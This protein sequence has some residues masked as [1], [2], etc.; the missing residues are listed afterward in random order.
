MLARSRSCDVSGIAGA[1][2]L[3]ARVSVKARA[4]GVEG[5]VVVLTAGLS[6]TAAKC[7]A[8]GR[9]DRFEEVAKGATSGR[10]DRFEEVAKGAASGRD[11]RFEEV[12]KDAASGR[13]DK[14][15]VVWRVMA[16]AMS[17]AA[18][19]VAAMGHALRNHGMAGWGDVRLKRAATRAA[20]RA[21][22]PAR[23]CVL[24][25]LLRTWSMRWSGCW[26]MG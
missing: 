7:A 23:G 3:G 8:S 5:S 6:A 26:L 17:R 15:L 25:R 10:D 16:A 11:D 2:W 20:M 13:D 24:R 19:V 22:R 18:A 14:F 12:A 21:S 9:D 1:G 4:S